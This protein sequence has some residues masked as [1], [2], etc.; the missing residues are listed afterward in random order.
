[1]DD[2]EIDLMFPEEYRDFIA[3]I[4]YK[5][6]WVCTVT[7]E[8]GPLNFSI[9]LGDYSKP[10]PLDGFTQALEHAQQRLRDLGEKV[11]N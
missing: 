6:E 11:S 3:E 4:A 5:S 10:F 8:L 2:F 7:Q 1:M 9:E